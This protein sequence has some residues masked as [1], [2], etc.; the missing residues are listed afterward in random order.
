MS[1]IWRASTADPQESRSGENP[2]LLRGWWA[3]FLASSIFNI[4]GLRSITSAETVA[5]RQP[6]AR[7]ELFTTI[8]GIAAG[9]ALLVITHRISEG[10]TAVGER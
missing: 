8:V 10:Q 7:L 2:W 4:V 1:E 6:L 9:V 5:D 3:L